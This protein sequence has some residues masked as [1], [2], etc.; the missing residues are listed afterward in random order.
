MPLSSP[1]LEKKQSIGHQKAKKGLG[2]T[3]LHL[4][5]PCVVLRRLNIVEPIF[6]YL[7]ILIE[8]C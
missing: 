6:G 7:V 2:P 4:K 1:K 8:R 3:G 5:E